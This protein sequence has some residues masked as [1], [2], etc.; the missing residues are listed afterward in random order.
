MTN[1][2]TRELHLPADVVSRVD[3]RLPY[4]EFETAEEYI[5]FIVTEVLYHTTDTAAN[6][7]IEPVDEEIVRD[8]LQALG[9]L[10]E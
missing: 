8:Q 6:D 2:E 3:D 1:Q 9:Y 4:T 7:D 5:A 10:T